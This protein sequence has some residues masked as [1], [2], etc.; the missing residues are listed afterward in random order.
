VGEEEALAL[1]TAY[2]ELKGVKADTTTSGKRFVSA[3]RK[4]ARR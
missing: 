4:R 3:R 1:L 2:A